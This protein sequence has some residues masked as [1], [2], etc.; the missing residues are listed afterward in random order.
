MAISC[1]QMAAWSGGR[2]AAVRSRPRGWRSG[3]LLGLAP[4]RRAAKAAS[5]RSASRAQPGLAAPSRD[6]ARFVCRPDPPGWLAQVSAQ[7]VTSH[8]VQPAA[9]LLGVWAVRLHS[10]RAYACRP[11]RGRLGARDRESGPSRGGHAD[12]GQG[13][14]IRAQLAPGRE[15]A[16]SRPRAARAV[17]LPGAPLFICFRGLPAPL[18]TPTR[19]VRPLAPGATSTRGSR[20]GPPVE[21]PGRLALAAP[22]S[23]CC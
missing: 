3:R 11:R 6:S 22:S 12:A 5:P 21:W 16:A 17:W 18:R 1:M 4:R 19:P 10:L 2:G 7:V 23:C 20:R 13:P 15:P 9:Y 8:T 14:C